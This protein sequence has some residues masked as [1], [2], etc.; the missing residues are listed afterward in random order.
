MKLYKNLTDG[1]KSALIGGI[2]ILVF[3]IVFS[4]YRQSRLEKL[5]SDFIWTEGTI[6]EIKLNVSKGTTQTQDIFLFEFKHNGENIIKSRTTYKPELLKVG[7]KFK[8]KV[9]PKDSDLLEIDF[10]GI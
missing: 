7:Q 3:G 1:K 6:T 10:N 8:I 9:H 4:I 5:D 2:L